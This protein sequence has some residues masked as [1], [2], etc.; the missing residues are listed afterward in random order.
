M[1]ETPHAN[2]SSDILI[3]CDSV[4]EVKFFN[5]SSNAT[6]FNWDFGDG[7][8]SNLIS[9]QNNYF[10]GIY[11]VTLISSNGVCS[12]TMIQ[13]NMIEVGANVVSDFVVS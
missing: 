8:T 5:N 1:K 7:N 10:T 2:F 4:K 13:S 11:S 6:D 3:T 9:P 12:D